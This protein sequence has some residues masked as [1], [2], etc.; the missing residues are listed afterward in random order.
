[1]TTQSIHFRLAIPAAD[2]LAYYKGRVREVVI[3]L[4]DGRRV[5]FP[6]SALQS[7]VSHQGIYGVFELRFD[8]QHKLLGLHRIGD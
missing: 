1:M 3:T 5:K 8:A 6:A 2:Y 7:V 4:S